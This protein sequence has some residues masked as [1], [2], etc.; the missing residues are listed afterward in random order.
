LIVPGVS[1]S[2]DKLELK[3]N[4]A[5]IS[6]SAGYQLGS[7][8][9]QQVGNV[10]AEAMIRGLEDALSSA[11]P[12]MSAKEMRTTLLE[13]KKQIAAKRQ[14]ERK[15]LAAKH[16][17]E[18]RAFL[19]ANAK[20]EGVVSMPSGLQYKVIKEGTGKPPGP[21]DSVTVN[22]RGTSINGTEFDNSHKRNA[23]ATFR[24]DS[25][26]RGW[27]EALQLMNVGSKSKLYLPSELAYGER[28]AGGKIPPNSPLI[29]EV[30]VI[31][32]SQAEEAKKKSE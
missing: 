7:D 5:K 16:Q 17:A 25:V 4:K 13:L 10:D 28:G 8:F 19:A 1:F 11:E 18:G 22:Y 29:F 15:Q 12:S 23:P 27:S 26:I 9:K 6:Y 2:A 32:I 30:E 21:K 31:S 3:D 20:K 14:Q 24:V